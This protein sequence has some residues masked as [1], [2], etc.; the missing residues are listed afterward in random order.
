[1]LLLQ[2]HPPVSLAPRRFG[3]RF[4]LLALALGLAAGSA[5]AEVQGFHDVRDVVVPAAGW[6][7]VPLDL[8]AVRHMAP[9]GADLHVFSRT[10]GEV[11][12]RI[13]PAPPRKREPAGRVV[14]ALAR[15]R[16][17]RMVS[18]RRRRIGAGPPPAPSPDAGP[19]PPGCSRPC[20]GE[21]GW[22]RVAA[23]RAGR[24]PD[25][26]REGRGHLSGHP[27]PLPAAALAAPAGRRPACRRSRWSRS[28]VRACRSPRPTPTAGRGR[29]APWSAPSL[30]RPRARPR[31]G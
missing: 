18:G 11:P 16:R 2:P 7:R 4:G 5:G 24:P 22:H 6:V 28:S 30:C 25:R 17:R 14:P 27:G 31:G 13:E 19:L 12:L 21:P 1:M 23:A 3:L 29:P 26:G 8:A 20:R 9:G 10:G 15:R